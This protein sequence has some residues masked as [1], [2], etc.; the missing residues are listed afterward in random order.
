MRIQALLVGT[1]IIGLAGSVAAQTPTGTSAVGTADPS[2]DVSWSATALGGG[3][4]SGGF[5]DAFVVNP[6]GGVWQP[7][8]AGV[9]QW[10]SAWP[11]ASASNG[12][13]DYNGLTDAGWRY[14][15]TFQSQFTSTAGVLNFT[16]GWDNIF[17]SFVLNG[18]SY[19][20]AALLTSTVDQSVD[21]HFGFCR[22][23]DAV[24]LGSNYP[25]CT[26]TFQVSGLVNGLNTVQVVLRGDGQTDGL[27]WYGETASVPTATDV[28]PEPASM[29]LLATG[30]IGLA[31]AARRKRRR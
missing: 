23:G 19:S 20:P 18:T 22:D 12:V 21:S 7:N 4:N 2:W 8:T 17:A 10:I 13:G 11:S 27:Y 9:T 31:G 24:L 15:Y 16:M 3:G 5:Y 14:T 1:L 26:S 30:L 28:V 29:T 6:V 25:N